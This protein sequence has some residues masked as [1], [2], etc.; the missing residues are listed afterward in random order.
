M[1]TRPRGAVT[2]GVAFR[3]TLAGRVAYN[4]CDILAREVWL[5]RACCYLEES[6]S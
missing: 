1:I 6:F 3:L 2:P 5:S 4:G